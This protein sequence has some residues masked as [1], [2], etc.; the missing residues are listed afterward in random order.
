MVMSDVLILGGGF[1]GVWCARRLEKLLP[2]EASILLISSENYFV[3]Q[4]LLPEVVGGSLAPSHVISPLRH[5]LRRTRVVRGEVS[6]VDCQRRLVEVSQPG[7]PHRL[8]FEGQQLVL[9]LGAVVD[10]SRMPGMAEHALFIRNLADALELRRVLMDRMEQAVLVEDAEERAALLTFVVV[11]GG[12]SGV[13]TAAEML[14]LCK[15]AQRFYPALH[16]ERIRVI[17]VHSRDTLLPELH[18]KLGAFAYRLLSQRGM[19]FRL[20]QRVRA[21]SSQAVYLQDGSC[22][23]SR[24]VVCSVGNAPHPVLQGLDLPMQKGKIVTDAS[25]QVAERHGIWAIGDCAQVPDGHGGISPPT[26]QFAVRQGD[27]L[28]RSILRQQQGKVT[29]PFKH[30]S[31]GQLATLG[32]RNAV[33]YTFGMRFSG[34]F[35]WW[36]WRT[37]YLF[38]L[39]RLD[40]KLQVVI[41]WTLRLFFPRD[42]TVLNPKPTLALEHI[43]LE[44][45][46]VLFQQ[47]D[48]SASFYVVESG[49][50]ELSQVD[51]AGQMVLR[52]E[53]DKGDH[54]GEGSLLRHEVRSTTAKALAPTTVQVLDARLCHRLVAHWTQLRHSLVST[55]RRFATAAQLLPEDVPESVLQ[56][57]C[58]QLMSQ[59]VVTLA[60]DANL[61]QGLRQFAAH[62]F[63][64]LPLVDGEGHLQGLATSTDLYRARQHE[65]ALSQPMLDC[66]S[67]DVRAVQPDDPARSLPHGKS[68]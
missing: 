63:S 66:C 68:T 41:D 40:R 4:P 47:G 33:A 42:V 7:S 3:F 65:Q 22:I 17:C 49:S 9:A 62:N 44:A 26:A 46:E 55:S 5:L 52:E 10:V 45:G 48:P 50:M 11:G 59:P 16:N 56:I 21:V 43:H 60:A 34:F 12:F 67:L 37:V 18:P 38:K 30:R 54:F 25:L 51:E 20:Q 24:T 53:L 2:K 13:E 64:C 39:P 31:E 27:H 29:V 28:A 35:A 1:A 32:H 6:R 19:E 57:P 58:Q 8:T 23:A 36:L 15:H 14:D 61:E